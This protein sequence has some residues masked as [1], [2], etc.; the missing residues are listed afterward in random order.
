MRIDGNKIKM[1]LTDSTF[2]YFN[3]L[4]KGGLLQIDSLA[5]LIIDNCEFH[6]F[7]APNGGRLLYYSDSADFNLII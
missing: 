7:D 1:K 3:S 4:T 6:Y 2:K 5:E